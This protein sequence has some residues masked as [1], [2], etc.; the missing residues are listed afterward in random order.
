M[1]GTIPDLFGCIE[2]GIGKLGFVEMENDLSMSRFLL[3]DISL[4]RLQIGARGGTGSSPVTP[5]APSP[6]EELPSA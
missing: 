1:L 6:Q 2:V 5:K 3:T 4:H